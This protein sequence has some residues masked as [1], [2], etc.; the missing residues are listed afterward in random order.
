MLL[1]R[2]FNYARLDLLNLFWAMGMYKTFFTTIVTFCVQP[3]LSFAWSISLLLVEPAT[4]EEVVGEEMTP[5]H[6]I[7]PTKSR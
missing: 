5:A 4:N 1:G 2:D 7:P 3:Y 6:N